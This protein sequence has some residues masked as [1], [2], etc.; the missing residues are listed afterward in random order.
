MELKNLMNDSKLVQ[1]TISQFYLAHFNLSSTFNYYHCSIVLIWL[2]IICYII[3]I[4]QLFGLVFSLEL[5]TL[6][7][8]YR[9]NVTLITNIVCYC[10]W[11]YY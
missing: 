7:F 3:V 2:T 9:T 5:N 4:R 10:L 11:H 6:V 8:N 1:Q